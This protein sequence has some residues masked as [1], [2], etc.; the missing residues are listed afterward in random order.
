MEYASQL[1]RREEVAEGIL[2]VHLA[3]PEGFR[4]RPGQWCFLNL[5]DRGLRDERGLRR[6]LSIASAPADEELLFATKRSE[7]AFKQ[8]LARLEPG[9]PISLEAPRGSLALPEDPEIPVALLAG[10]IGITPFRSL[11]RHELSRGSRRPITLFYSNRR[12]EEAPFLEELQAMDR[13]AEAFRLVATMT[14]MHLSSTPWDGPTRRLDSAMIR[15]GCPGWA[16]AHFYLAGPPP[17]VDA[18]AGVVREMGVS[19][20]RVHPEKFVGY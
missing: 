4:F 9:D 17:M 1:L 10:G 2:A 5:P 12:P 14:R 16:Q 3:R 13:R 11:L 19:P 8:T 18:M 15:E 7:S 6:H 20:E